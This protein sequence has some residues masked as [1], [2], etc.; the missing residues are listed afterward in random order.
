MLIRANPYQFTI[1]F[2]AIST[3][4]PAM[5]IIPNT[6]LVSLLGVAPPETLNQDQISIVRLPLHFPDC[7]NGKSIKCC[8]KPC[9]AK[10]HATTYVDL[11][12]MH[13]SCSSLRVSVNLVSPARLPAMMPALLTRES[14][15]VDLPW[16]TWAITDMLRMLARLS[17]MDRT[18]TQGRGKESQWFQRVRCSVKHLTNQQ[19]H[20][21]ICKDLCV[22]TRLVLATIHYILPVL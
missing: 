12:V 15:N 11:M 5:G 17:M 13:L 1:R 2:T 21:T 18:Y 16:S 22:H 9:M 6:F 3:A 10:L 19:A 8:R 20:S 4:D 7:P 14:V